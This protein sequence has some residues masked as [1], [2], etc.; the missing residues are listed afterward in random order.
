MTTP[1]AGIAYLH[2]MS[3]AHSRRVHAG[4]TDTNSAAA[5]STSSVPLPVSVAIRRNMGWSTLRWGIAACVAL[6]VTLALT[7]RDVSPECTYNGRSISMIS[8]WVW[9]VTARLAA[10]SLLR[11]LIWGFWDV[12]SGPDRQ[13]DHIYT[14]VRCEF[15]LVIIS[16]VWLTL[17]FLYLYGS[18]PSNPSCDRS[19]PTWGMVQVVL[20]YAHYSAPI[21][22]ALLLRCVVACGCCSPLVRM[23]QILAQVG[24]FTA[25]QLPASEA[26][27]RKLPKERY[28][29]GRFPSEEAP[30]C[31]IC[32]AEYAHGEAIR[33]L[34]CAGGN[35]HF[36]VACIDVWLRQHASCPVCRTSMI[37]PAWALAREQL[38]QIATVTS[39]IDQIQDMQPRTALTGTAGGVAR[40]DVVLT[41]GS[42]TGEPRSPG[43]QVRD[44]G[45]SR[46]SASTATGL[47]RSISGRLM[48]SLSE[49][50]VSDAELLQSSARPASARTLT[51]AT[52]SAAIPLGEVSDTNT[53]QVGQATF[54]GAVAPPAPPEPDSSPQLRPTIV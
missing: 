33:V 37:D 42:P 51:V 40:N 2:R 5:A 53:A 16:V 27:I 8:I 15:S 11:G 26:Q 38:A 17:G 41:S 54:A 1:D 50:A 4:G 48:R 47:P 13:K 19:L 24:I 34:P 6:G 43:P 22:L 21:V 30:Q 9:V 36:H 45:S 12:S 32:L 31:V 3:G 18:A 35:H 28:R 7:R 14:L 44:T 46:S 52:L 25:P 49:G 39:G 10:S 23:L 29:A 20:L